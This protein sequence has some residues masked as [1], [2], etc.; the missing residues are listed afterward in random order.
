M[1]P[2]TID[3]LNRSTSGPF[4]KINSVD[5]FQT[6]VQALPINEL[7]IL[8]PTLNLMDPH[9]ATKLAKKI[10]KEKRVLSP[11]SAIRSREIF[12]I[13]LKA[14]NLELIS[15]NQLT[16]LHILDAAYRDFISHACMYTYFECVVKGESHRECHMFPLPVGVNQ[17][18]T[19]Q[20]NYLETAFPSGVEVDESKKTLKEP[21][22]KRFFAFTNTEWSHFCELMDN[23]TISEQKFYLVQ[24]P[25]YGCH[26]PITMKIQEAL[27][28]CRQLEILQKL[29]DGAVWSIQVM[30]VPSFSMFQNVLKVKARTLNREPVKLIPTYGFLPPKVYAFTKK[31][32]GIPFA[33]YFP[34]ADPNERYNLNNSRFKANFDGWQREGP[35]AALLHD[36]Y[37]ALR[38]MAMAENIA[39]AR[40]HLAKIA[41]KHPY[42]RVNSKSREISDIL[43]DGELIHSYPRS[44]DTIF[45]I[46]KDQAKFGDL[47]DFIGK[48]LHPQ[49]KASFLSDMVVKKEVWKKKYSLGREDLLETDQQIYDYLD[50]KVVKMEIQHI[51]NMISMGIRISLKKETEEGF[52][53]LA[54]AASKGCVNILE[55]LLEEGADVEEKNEKSDRALFQ[56][57]YSVNKEAVKILLKYKASVNEH[58]VCGATPLELACSKGH[59]R[60]V[61]RLLLK[62][63]LVN[64]KNKM[65][66]ASPLAVAAEHGFLEIINKLLRKDADVNAK[67]MD[68]DTVLHLAVKSKVTKAVEILLQQ[69][70]ILIDEPNNLGNT[71]L[72]E[73]CLKESYNEIE[74]LLK[75]GA[76]IDY[77]N[78]NN[79]QT[80]LGI[81]EKKGDLKVFDLL[82]TYEKKEATQGALDG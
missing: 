60:I 23:E 80:A 13:A 29:N 1:V 81:A 73:A 21:I 14:L 75:Y 16:S 8:N 47:F 58:F 20:L 79:G 27:Y 24:V 33:L 41:K 65:T 74:V 53:T 48:N 62:G 25:Q 44:I 40:F 35:F 55:K 9:K 4:F 26:S 50:G 37:H 54:L 78:P 43:I 18:T 11:E 5:D 39:K 57:I 17:K 12:M 63:A 52:L 64:V 3:I 46:R 49:L 61:K 19:M 38:E 34:E 67:N 31:H 45:A 10:S 69:E 76:S 51:E 72:M 70:N 59:L 2:I 15:L 6:L 82:M 7:K 32:K 66:G 68:G 42:D 28:L 36:F 56:A 77:E 71:P 30:A 22:L